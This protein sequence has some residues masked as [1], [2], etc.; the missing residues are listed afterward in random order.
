MKSRLLLAILVA[1]WATPAYPWVLTGHIY[2]TAAIQ[3]QLGDV[4][5]STDFPLTPGTCAGDAANP[6]W[7]IELGT[8][9]ARWNTATD[10]FNFT[11]DP[12]QGASVPGSCNS[13]DPNSVFFLVNVC[14][15]S[16]FGA[17]TLAV[18][19]T[20]SFASGEAIH[21]DIVFNTAKTW[22][23]FDGPLSGMP[24]V[25]DFRRVATHESGHV[26]G[27]NHPPHASTVMNAFVSDVIAPLADDLNG[28]KAVY[29]AMTL[30]NAGDVN[31]NGATDLAS[32]RSVSDGTTTVDIRDSSDGALLRRMNYLTNA[33]TSKGGAALP[34]L[35]GNGARELA[36][37]AVRNSD[38]LGVI[39]IRNMSGDEMPRLIWLSAG[40]FPRKIL[41]LYDADGNGV[42][43][44]A[45][46]MEK[47]IDGSVM[48]EI[49]NAFGATGDRQLWFEPGTTAHDMVVLDPFASE[50][51][52][53]RIAVLLSQFTNNFGLVQTKRPFGATSPTTV[54]MGSGYPG[55]IRVRRLAAIADADGDGV[56]EVAIVA[57]RNAGGQIVAEIRNA[58]G[59]ANLRRIWF[60]TGHTLIAAEGVGTSATNLV[61]DLA[62]ASRRT[63]DGRIFVET[64]NAFG[65][66]TRQLTWFSSTFEAAAAIVALPDSNADSLHE[67]VLMLSRQS[68]GRMMLQ[69]RNLNDEATVILNTWLGDSH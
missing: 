13:A 55:G 45:V 28:V 3:I 57:T 4:C 51:G 27:L 23:A 68:D 66:P 15:T 20:L 59:L 47:V 56:S 10:L 29:G 22:S 16:T 5:D 54:R 31:L 7:R 6:D 65:I 19:R 50:P 43:E 36:V 21:S 64:G 58:S 35:D 18:A 61:P 48:V 24:G 2:R 37:L 38:G 39:E 33:F 63:S 60:A 8:A 12:A 17:S 26:M 44:L 1:A 14:A 52:V 49:R 62:V 32:I 40:F 46:L 67:A 41:P 25:N 9:L 53:S 11:T 30:I 42:A 69:K 34:D